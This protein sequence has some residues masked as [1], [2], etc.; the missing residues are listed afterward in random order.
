MEIKQLQKL[1]PTYSVQEIQKHAILA[2]SSGEVDCVIDHRKE[3]INFNTISF[4]SQNVKSKLTEISR[5]LRK[6]VQ[7]IDVNR[8]AEVRLQRI[9]VISNCNVAY[10]ISH[11]VSWPRSARPCSR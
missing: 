11:S 3:V 6:C 10:V 2:R 4:A 5:N 9:R 7:Q 1:F 8:E